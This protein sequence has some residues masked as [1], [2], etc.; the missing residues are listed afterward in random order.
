MVSNLPSLD[1][2]L[3]R[4]ERRYVRDRWRD[5]N[6]QDSFSRLYLIMSGKGVLSH[7]GETFTLTP[8]KIFLIPEYTLHDYN[9]F[10]KMEL[11]FIHFQ[12][13]TPGELSFFNQY[14]C[15]YQIEVGSSGIDVQDFNYI[16]DRSDH[17]TPLNQ[18]Q[19]ASKLLEIISLFIVAPRANL[20]KS[21]YRDLSRLMIVINHMD[22]NLNR[23][24]KVEEWS[25]LL[26]MERS[27]FTRYFSKVLGLSPGRYHRKKRIEAAMNLLN[28]SK[29]SCD[30]IGHKLGFYDGSHFSRIFFNETGLRPGDYRLHR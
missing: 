20:S 3:N 14:I 26:N 25:S 30:E 13:R 17:H 11:Y 12:L 8:G 29:L 1:I 21:H 15:R 16:M 19:V 5:K 23:E 4:I 10:G 18:L 2:T 6:Y 24:C 28:D 9:H 7:S 22:E 27:S